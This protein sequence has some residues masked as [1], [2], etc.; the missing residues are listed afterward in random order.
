LAGFEPH[1]MC[2]FK[3][4]LN[5]IELDRF[6]VALQTEARMQTELEALAAGAKKG[7]RSRV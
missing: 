4:V 5:A 6:E 1:A 3:R 7:K 2:R